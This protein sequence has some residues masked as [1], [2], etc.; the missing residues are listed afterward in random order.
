AEVQIV[1]SAQHSRWARGRLNPMQDA[2]DERASKHRT[3]TTKQPDLPLDPRLP[4]LESRDTVLASLGFALL[5]ILATLGC[6]SVV[7]IPKRHIRHC[8]LEFGDGNFEI[9]H[10]GV[11]HRD[12]L[13]EVALDA[14]HRLS[15][16]PSKSAFSAA[17]ASSTGW[18]LA[19]LAL[20]TAFSM[21]ST[22]SR[23]WTSTWP[24]SPVPSSST[25]FTNSDQ[26]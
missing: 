17:T 18:L 21:A 24:V 5:A 1:A 14:H 10:G 22:W 16:S 20:A 9:P 15:V 11:Q 12:A 4:P 13:T 19:R 23:I 3:D 8:S 26:S 2:G 7:G 25:Y 6:L